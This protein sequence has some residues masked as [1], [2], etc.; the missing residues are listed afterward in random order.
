MFRGLILSIGGMIL[1]LLIGD[2]AKSQDPK[3]IR[4]KYICFIVL[5]IAGLFIPILPIRI[6][7]CCLIA[8]TV[9]IAY[10]TEYIK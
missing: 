2:K 1:E 3:I 10:I 7:M 6:M 8:I 4:L 9:S 5:C